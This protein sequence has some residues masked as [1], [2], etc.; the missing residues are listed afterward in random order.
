MDSGSSVTENSPLLDRCSG[1]IGGLLTSAGR[2]SITKVRL[3]GMI[4]ATLMLMTDFR[5]WNFSCGE[6]GSS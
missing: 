3:T 2:V 1:C 6:P 5:R 4:S